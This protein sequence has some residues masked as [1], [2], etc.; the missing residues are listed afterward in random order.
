MDATIESVICDG[1]GA[2]M[3]THTA[4]P[5]HYG[6]ILQAQDFNRN[7]TGYTYAVGIIPPIAKPCHF[8]GFECLD[9]WRQK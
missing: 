1:C 8:C 9:E 6:L 3:I 2:E 4:N 5:A 7:N